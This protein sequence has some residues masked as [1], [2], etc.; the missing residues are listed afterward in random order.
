MSSRGE[1][2]D[3][4]VCQVRT[5]AAAL[6]EGLRVGVEGS[7]ETSRTRRAVDR[8]GARGERQSA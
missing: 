2:P 7:G 6:V 5:A 3:L 1:K 4:T 8:S